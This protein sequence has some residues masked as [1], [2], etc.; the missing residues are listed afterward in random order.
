GSYAATAWGAAPNATLQ[1]LLHEFYNV[2]TNVQSADRTNVAGVM[3]IEDWQTDLKK[4]TLRVTWTNVA[5]GS[6]GEFSQSVYLHR[7]S[8]YGEGA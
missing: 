6:A 2:L 1:D 5:S 3:V 7:N 8:N 4:V